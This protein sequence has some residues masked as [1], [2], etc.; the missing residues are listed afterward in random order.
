MLAERHEKH[1]ECPDVT[2]FEGIS[3]CMSMQRQLLAS[4]TLFTNTRP[5]SWTYL[6]T[7][8]T[9]PIKSQNRQRWTSP[10]ALLYSREVLRALKRNVHDKR[11]GGAYHLRV[12]SKH[13]QR[14]VFVC[15][16][17]LIFF[18]WWVFRQIL[19]LICLKHKM[20][21]CICLLSELILEKDMLLWHCKRGFS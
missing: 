18:W 5:D 10:S 14:A 21:V 7:F 8:T 20:C 6:L 4:K 19:M 9:F 15:L 1:I 2:A 12:K 17:V 11:H 13:C 16:W 3:H